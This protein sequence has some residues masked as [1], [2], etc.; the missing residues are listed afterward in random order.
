[1][2][3]HELI[4]YQIKLEINVHGVYLTVFGSSNWLSRNLT[5]SAKSVEKELYTTQTLGT[6][7]LD[8]N[9]LQGYPQRSSPIFP[10][11]L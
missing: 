11:L 10:S 9:N 3:K 2:S 1:M 5:P 4:N 8:I 7:L 6:Y